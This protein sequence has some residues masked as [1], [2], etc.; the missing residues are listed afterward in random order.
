[1]SPPDYDA[2][3]VAE[4]RAYVLKKL[5]MSEQDFAA[6]MALRSSAGLVRSSVMR[7]RRRRV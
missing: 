7:P 3:V 6:Y 2:D 1:M 4:D 5:A